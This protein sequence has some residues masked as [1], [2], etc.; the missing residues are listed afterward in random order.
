MNSKRILSVIVLLLLVI[1]VSYNKPI[2]VKD[3]IQPYTNEV[4][5]KKINSSI[6]FSSYSQKEL[7]VTGEESIKEIVMLLGD[8]KV[9][10]KLNSPNPYRPQIKNTY[11]LIFLDENNKYQSINILNSKYIEINHKPYKI[12]G[13]PN[14]P[15]I[16]TS[17]ILDQPIGDLD[18]FY[19][20]LIHQDE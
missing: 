20:N 2:Q 5:P 6:F 14:I 10:R 13:T 19:Y 7:N 4:L 9:R 15:S 1:I 11:N 17:I 3:L 18:E 12:I 8:M 16:Y